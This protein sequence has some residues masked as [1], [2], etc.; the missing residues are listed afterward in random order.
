[1]KSLHTFALAL[2]ALVPV[3][4]CATQPADETDVGDVAASEIG[5][6]DFVCDQPIVERHVKNAPFANVKT[7]KA[8][9]HDGY[10]RWVMTFEGNAMPNYRVERADSARFYDG[11][12]NPLSLAGNAGM[13]VIVEGGTGA[14]SYGGAKRFKPVGSPKN[15]TETALLGDYEGDVGW[16]LGLKQAACYRVFEISNPPGI[17][18]DVQTNGPAPA[19]LPDVIAGAGATAIEPTS[20]YVCDATPIVASRPHAPFAQVSSVRV[21]GHASEG[22]DR[23]VLELT[24]ESEMPNFEVKSQDSAK[25]GNMTLA[26]SVGLT[27]TLKG[28]SGKDA[29]T[30]E[31][32]YHGFTRY[33]G[34]SLLREAGLVKDA[35]G[36][37]T[38]GLGLDHTSCYR[39][40][41]LQHPTRLV[42]DVQR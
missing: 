32:T 28:A 34:G 4:A 27:V 5:L 1:M 37:V 16:G 20:D 8:A 13:S 40:Y 25:F 23:F 17:V 11:N 29:T 14:Q 3:T 35:N 39:A 42:V 36:S 24:D 19:P 21:G 10:D 22:F 33:A 6:A 18:V 31:K 12:G 9:S 2:V 26:G 15:M 7:V 30:G 41:T 38:W